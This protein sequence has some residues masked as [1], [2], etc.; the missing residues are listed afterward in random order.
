M[1]M[2]LMYKKWTSH[3]RKGSGKGFGTCHTNWKSKS[4]TKRLGVHLNLPYNEIKI[5]RPFRTREEGFV[6]C[7]LPS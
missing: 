3:K 4:K 7:H 1:E 5:H 6:E 2:K